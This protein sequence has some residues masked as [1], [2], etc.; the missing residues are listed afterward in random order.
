MILLKFRANSLGV[1][2]TAELTGIQ[3]S[4]RPLSLPTLIARAEW[5]RSP[6]YPQVR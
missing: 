3:F 5:E 4:I 2:E 1:L 6:N